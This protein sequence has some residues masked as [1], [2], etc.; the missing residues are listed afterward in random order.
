MT[1]APADLSE[2]FSPFKSYC[3]CEAFF[4]SPLAAPKVKINYPIPDSL[5]IT[6]GWLFK[7]LIIM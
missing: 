2:V 1:F 4:D 5:H 7:A 6:C 3:T